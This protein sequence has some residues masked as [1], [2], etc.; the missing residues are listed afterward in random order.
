M[1]L[2]KGLVCILFSLVWYA[3]KDDVPNGGVIVE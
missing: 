3:N 1:K 2:V